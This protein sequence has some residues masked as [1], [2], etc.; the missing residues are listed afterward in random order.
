MTSRDA[1]PIRPCDDPWDRDVPALNSVVPLE[2][3]SAYDMM[4]VIQSVVDEREFFELMP[5]YAKNIVTGFGRMAGRTVGI[6]GNN[7]RHA[8]GCLDINASVKGARFV[9]FCDSFNIPIITFEDVPGFLPGTAQVRFQMSVLLFVLAVGV[10][11]NL[12]RLLSS[13]SLFNQDI[14]CHFI[15]QLNFFIYKT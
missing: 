10:F 4:D 11:C 2:S 12:R 5:L 8:A 3:T 7:P 6:V 14:C 1:A 13:K 9:R 15:C